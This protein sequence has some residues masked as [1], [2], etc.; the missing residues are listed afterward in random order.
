M[1]PNFG[2]ALLSTLRSAS[3]VAVC[4]WVHGCY[5]RARRPPNFSRDLVHQENLDLDVLDVNAMQ[6]LNEGGY[7]TPVTCV[8]AT[9]R[10]KLPSP[11]VGMPSVM[12]F[13]HLCAGCA[14]GTVFIV[15]VRLGREIQFC[16]GSGNGGE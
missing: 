3:W 8:T 10:R 1:E 16:S 4:H 9:P 6:L 2:N 12:I 13:W 14:G 7:P 5:S 15:R 11:G